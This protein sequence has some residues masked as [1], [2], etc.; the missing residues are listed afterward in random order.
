M[1]IF[2]LGLTLALGL[3]SPGIANAPPGDEICTQWIVPE[4]TEMAAMPITKTGNCQDE[5]SC[6]ILTQPATKCALDPLEVIDPGDES[7]FG[8][9]YLESTQF[10]TCEVASVR[11]GSYT[12]TGPGISP[13]AWKVVLCSAPTAGWTCQGTWSKI[14]S[15]LLHLHQVS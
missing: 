5:C 14:S 12:I 4:E 15:G 3:S 6:N 8:V 1:F 2:F 9:R 13:R 10:R 7:A 11:K